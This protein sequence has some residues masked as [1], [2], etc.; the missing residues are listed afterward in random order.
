MRATRVESDDLTDYSKGTVA[1][2]WICVG[3]ALSIECAYKK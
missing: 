3:P 1:L 2:E